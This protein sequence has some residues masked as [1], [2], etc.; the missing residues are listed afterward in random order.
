[1]RDSGIVPKDK[2]SEVKT[3]PESPTTSSLSLS[4]KLALHSQSMWLPCLHIH[5]FLWGLP[6]IF[7]TQPLCTVEADNPRVLWEALRSDFKGIPT[8]SERK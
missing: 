8:T 7:Q 3:V 1:M 6:G 5:S 4:F 2:T